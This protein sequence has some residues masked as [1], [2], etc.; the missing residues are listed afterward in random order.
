MITING[1]NYR[2]TKMPPRQQVHVMRRLTPLL[3]AA[4]PAIMGFLDKDKP[5]ALV[6]QTVLQ[7]IGPFTDALSM[8]PDA[9]IDYVMNY[10]LVRVERQDAT[11]MTWHPF[12]VWRS[13]EV[14]PMYPN[15]TDAI[16]ELRLVG[17]VVKENL[18]GFF[19][20]LTGAL[21]S[22]PDATS[23]DQTA[24]GETQATS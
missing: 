19:G 13:D 21:G 17:E 10:C 6:F 18:S 12:Y 9:E 20:Q 7:S 14:I 16:A 24:A 4:A 3:K 15:D 1:I 22:L 8:M 11:T 23:P 5:K 2:A